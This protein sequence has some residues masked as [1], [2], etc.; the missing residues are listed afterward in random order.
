MQFKFMIAGLAAALASSGA[1]P[2]VFVIGNGLGGEC[3]QK[4]K[5][6]YSSFRQAEETCTRALREQAMTRANRAATYVNRGVLRMREGQHDKAVLDY[7]DALKLEPG[8]G[9]AFL[10]KGAAFIHQRDFSSAIP[11]L[12]QAIAFESQDLFAAYYNRAIAK[13]NTGDVT[14]AYYDFQ[15]ALELFSALG[16]KGLYLMMAA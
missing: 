7:N 14:G 3:Y 1:S 9:A 8:L 5:S 12:D 10:N 13:E 6:A 15:K 2:Q 11:T 16:L 4:T